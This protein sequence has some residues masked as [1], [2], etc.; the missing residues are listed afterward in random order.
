MNKLA[1]IALN[2]GL[3]LNQR[4]SETTANSIDWLFKR[5]TRRFAKRQMTWFRKE[6]GVHWILVERD[7][8]FERIVRSIVLLIEQFL[9]TLEPGV[10]QTITIGKGQI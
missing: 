10:M 8:P 9:G 2:Q 4:M 6:P 5:D 1:K 3:A 7:E